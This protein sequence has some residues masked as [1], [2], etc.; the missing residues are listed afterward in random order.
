MRKKRDRSGLPKRSKIV[1]L[2]LWVHIRKWFTTE[3][4]LFWGREVGTK[5]LEPHMRP[6]L[7]FL[8]CIQT[9]LLLPVPLTHFKTKII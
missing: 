9:N 8:D 4:T 5:P 2:H 1:C 7:I 6:G 3:E